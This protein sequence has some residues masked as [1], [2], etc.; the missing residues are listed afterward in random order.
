MGKIIKLKNKKT[1]ERVYPVTVTKAVADDASG[2]RLNDILKNKVEEAPMNDKQY[3]RVNGAWAE[4]EGGA[5]SETALI[6]LT[7]NDGKLNGVS[8]KVTTNEGEILLDTTWQGA[9]LSV[10]VRAGLTYT[11]TVGDK[12]GYI[13]PESVSYLAVKGAARTITMTYIESKLTVEIISNQGEDSAI[14]GVKA[15]VKYG[16]TTVQVANGGS[17]A[18][19]LNANVTI[20]FPSVEGYKTPE[21]ITYTHTG[22]AYVKSGTYQTEIVS[23]SL[24]ADNNQSV[25]GQIVTINGT[26]HTW[27]GSVISQKVPFGT[28][29][30]V[31]VNA[32]SGYTAPTSKS[33]V[34]SQQ[35][36]EVSM[37]YEKI[38]FGAFVQGV[39]G[40]LY[41][42]G[43]WN[44]QEEACGVAVVNEHFSCVVSPSFFHDGISIGETSDTVYNLAAVSDPYNDFNGL[45]NTTKIANSISSTNFAAGYCLSCKNK[46]GKTG[47]LG[48]SGEMY[49]IL[50]GAA[51]FGTLYIALGGSYSQLDKNFRTST[52]GED[53]SDGIQKFYGFY[54][55]MP[56]ISR[57][58]SQSACLPLFPL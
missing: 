4:V 35:Y 37:I 32:K 3:A 25:N 56:I 27:N 57:I 40:K 58:D 31:S 21:A 18:L 45:H 39:S 28:T 6:S 49:A 5:V 12:E 30:S 50:E 42:Y 22:G 26:Q 53:D 52:R 2:E 16:S 47:Y 13:K 46:R 54:N 34:A 15:T 20:T 33:F 19:P 38:E 17:V 43:E 10:Q 29:Y 48:S 24:S 11:V 41:K 14:S 44:N 9:Q 36:R 23:V 7:P 8:V 55:R 1:G 51:N